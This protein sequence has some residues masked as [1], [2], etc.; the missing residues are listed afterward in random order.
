MERWTLFTLLCV[1]S[2]VGTTNCS[3]FF[4]PEPDCYQP[5]EAPYDYQVPDYQETLQGILRALQEIVY[6][7]VQ[8]AKEELDE[9][10]RLWLPTCD[11]PY[12]GSGGEAI[13]EG[14]G[15]WVQESSTQNSVNDEKNEVSSSGNGIKDSSNSSSS[16]VSESV[17]N[18]TRTKITITNN[19]VVHK[20][21][22]GGLSGNNIT[23]VTDNPSTKYVEETTESSTLSNTV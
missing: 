16:S 7:T 1:F 3:P 18:G 14:E 20:Q 5:T 11:T 21:T 23:L 10:T 4:F 8:S 15:A 19:T 13:Q 2:F 17:I 22:V 9:L 6:I 12:P